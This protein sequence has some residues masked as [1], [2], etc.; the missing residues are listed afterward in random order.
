MEE[1]T[2]PMGPTPARVA[3]RAIGSGV[4]NVSE[5]PTQPIQRRLGPLS[6]VRVGDYQLGDLLG[7]G[8]SAEVYRAEDLMLRRVVAVKVLSASYA[9]DAEYTGRFRA[10]ACRVGSFSHPHLVPVYY[11][12][13]AEVRGK[14]LLYL[15]MPLLRES[16]RDRRRREGKLPVDEAVSLVQQ[17]A[18][19]LGA[20]HRSG[21]V[22]RDVKPGNVLLDADGHPLL[23][24]FGIACDLHA[25][26]SDDAATQ[27]GTVM[28]TPQYMAPEQ[29]C[30]DPVDQRADVYALGVM[31][32]ELLTGELP[33]VGA[34]PYLLAAQTL[35][36]PLIPPS[37]F[38]P[39]IPPD[40]EQ[41]VLRAL[42]RD[43]ADRYPDA[44]TFAQALGDVCV[45]EASASGLADQRQKPL[46]AIPAWSPQS[47]RVDRGLS[48]IDSVTSISQVFRDGMW[49]TWQR[50]RPAWRVAGRNLWPRVALVAL[51]ATLLTGLG[52]FIA[53]TQHSAE[54][55]T[56]ARAGT[57]YEPSSAQSRIPVSA[58]VEQTGPRQTNTAPTSGSSTPLTHV[59]QTGSGH[60]G[61]N[62]GKDGGGEKHGDSHSGSGDGGSNDS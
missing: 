54:T 47:Q 12:G 8:G 42:A 24:D 51:L 35:H 27:S 62:Y 32:Y 21:V 11:A 3:I 60:H 1:Q 25:V 23:A 57:L 30:G 31:L 55:M 45:T 4:P 2:I 52:G 9:D 43:S 26:A 41:V 39:G 17:V 28:G 53:V 40:V 13:E 48:A 7:V 34:T 5:W 49:D 58:S 44:E 29:L 10:E 46:S 56:D 36:A 33:F 16:L 59:N 14:R 37:S 15:V 6:G 38:E 20:A 50:W 19:G 61:D 22:H 18:D